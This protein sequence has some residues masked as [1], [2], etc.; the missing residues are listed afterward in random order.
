VGASIGYQNCTWGIP[1]TEEMGRQKLDGVDPRHLKECEALRAKEMRDC[2]QLRLDA[3][4]KRSPEP[5]YPE[6]APKGEP[7]Y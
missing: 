4:A 1:V 3:C 5:D 6:D 7:S 2:E